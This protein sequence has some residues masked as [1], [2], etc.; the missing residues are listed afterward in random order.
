MFNYFSFFALLINA[1]DGIALQRNRI[2]GIHP[3]VGLM[4]DLCK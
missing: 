1:V 4:S 3:D 2:T